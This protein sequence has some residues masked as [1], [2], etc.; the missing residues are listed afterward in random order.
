MFGDAFFQAIAEGAN[1]STTSYRPCLVYLNGE[2]WGYYGLREKYSGAY[3]ENNYG[4]DDDDVVISKLTGNTWETTEGDPDANEEYLKEFK[5]FY[6]KKNFKS[7]KVY[8]E[9]ITKYIDKD[10][11]I[12]ALILEAFAHN[13]DYV[14]NSNNLQMWRT[15]VI[16]EGVPY[17]DGKLRICM[18]DLDFALQHNT[19]NYLVPKEYTGTKSNDYSYDRFILYHNLLSNESFRAD[20]AARTKELFETILAPERT[21][22]ILD[23]M[24]AE[25]EPF[26]DD[27]AARW[28][29][30][31][32]KQAWLDQINILRTRLSTRAD[33]F[34]ATTLAM[35][36]PFEDDGS[37]LVVV[38]NLNSDESLNNSREFKVGSRVFEV[39]FYVNNDKYSSS[40]ARAFIR[41]A[42]G[43]KYFKIYWGTGMTSSQW[44]S[45]S[46]QEGASSADIDYINVG[47]HKINIKYQKGSVELT[48]DDVFT[49]SFKVA[50]DFGTVETFTF[51]SMQCKISCNRIKLILNYGLGSYKEIDY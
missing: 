8:N 43:D 25:L 50:S 7:E 29:M 35:Y 18:H 26:F 14:A 28:G 33:Y 42:A 11:F 16:K 34:V 4:V 45:G 10:S 30:G 12:D 2:F 48:V 17:Y 3:F 39:E 49:K 9:L 51:G 20:L 21:T 47:K 15:S 5:S 40:N 37:T 23:R 41:F 19:G 31:Y 44:M 1:C 38:D 36:E 46:V 22:A 27:N 13:W 32:T 6:T 24:A